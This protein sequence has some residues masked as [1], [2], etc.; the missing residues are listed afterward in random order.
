MEAKFSIIDRWAKQSL[1]A[2]AAH[3]TEVGLFAGS[4]NLNSKN[5]RFYPF[6]RSGEATPIAFQEPDKMH[7]FVRLLCKVFKDGRDL[8]FSPTLRASEAIVG[9]QPLVLSTREIN[10]P[11]EAYFVKQPD[12]F[13]ADQLALAI[14]GDVE[15]LDTRVI[16]IED[17]IPFIGT[18]PR[19][20]FNS[21]NA[22]AEQHNLL[23]IC[24]CNVAEATETAAYLAKHCHNLCQLTASEE[25]SLETD[26][27]EPKTVQCFSLSYG[28]PQP[29]RI[30]Y[31]LNDSG[32]IVIPA[33]PVTDL[34]R[35]KECGEL[36]AQQPIL[37]SKF[38]DRTVGFFRFELKPETVLSMISQAVKHGVLLRSGS[39][40]KHTTITRAGSNNQ[41][42]P[43][44]GNRA[45]TS[46]LD[47]Y[48]ESTNFSR[49]FETLC[50]MGDFRI[51]A[52]EDASSVNATKSLVL[53]LIKAIVSGDRTL[54][55][56]AVTAH[57]NTVILLV[58]NEIGAENIRQKVGE[59]KNATFEVIATNGAIT[60]SDFLSLYKA[61]LNQ[62]QPDFLFVLNFNCVQLSA[63][64][65]NQLCKEMIA[66]SRG[67]T[68]IAQTGCWNPDEQLPS[69]DA[70]WLVRAF[71]S[72]VLRKD[73][74]EITGNH[75]PSVYEFLA[76]SEAGQKQFR[77][78]FMLTTSG[79]ELV[80][81]AL[82]KTLYLKSLFFWCEGTPARELFA[83]SDVDGKVLNEKTVKRLLT[84][85]AK[86]DIVRLTPPT[87]KGVK[88]CLVTFRK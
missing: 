62:K 8:P 23:L 64:S 52:A 79:D 68:T 16:I 35:M 51:L 66:S 71:M 12:T 76:H 33:T 57:R 10:V 40:Q 1:P 32:E 27:G 55:F 73:Y 61:T 72:P 78:R 83:M 65:F 59:P 44:R 7:A 36:F 69:E 86:L 56:K 49:G 19:E 43:Y 6:A 30:I 85:A 39:G 26:S 15:T 63:Y 67:V 11:D 42:K 81:A 37:Q 17:L 9:S 77:T 4:I 13:N 47:Q 50:N 29:Q 46:R 54:D 2:I 5:E 84:E 60:D 31:S 18:T 74:L 41:R 24:G 88:D 38:I 34:V 21:L 22:V 58:G 70:L 87:R 25:I 3:L 82:M 53:K 80:P 14:A 20:A 48:S 28:N 45:L 75:F